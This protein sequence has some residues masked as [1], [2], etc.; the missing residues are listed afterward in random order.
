MC[1]TLEWASV[2]LERCGKNKMSSDGDNSGSNKCERSYSGDWQNLRLVGV[3]SQAVSLVMVRLAGIFF[4]H[5]EN[6]HI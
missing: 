2:P 5:R 4:T 3:W 6:V 1:V